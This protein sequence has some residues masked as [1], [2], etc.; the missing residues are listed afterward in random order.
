M[1]SINVD[2]SRKADCGSSFIA[3]LRAPNV[4]QELA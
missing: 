4:L 2:D 1:S 3:I